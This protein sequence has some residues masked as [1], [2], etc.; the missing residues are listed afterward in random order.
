MNAGLDSNS[1]KH[2]HSLPPWPPSRP[3]PTT[4]WHSTSCSFH[5]SR[6]LRRPTGESCA[7]S[8]HLR[9]RYSTY[10]P[11]PLPS[12]LRPHPHLHH[13]SYSP[14]GNLQEQIYTKQSAPARYNMRTTSQRRRPSEMTIP[15]GMSTGASGHKIGCSERNQRGVSK[16]SYIPVH[17]AFFPQSTDCLY[18]HIYDQDRNMYYYH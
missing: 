9:F 3:P 12:P 15:S 1:E 2:A 8:P 6:S 5:A 16:S 18:A 10:P 17:V 11:S 7:L 4:C 13:P 14:G